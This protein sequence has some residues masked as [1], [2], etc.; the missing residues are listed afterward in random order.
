MV[1]KKYKNLE[2]F[3]KDGMK[4]CWDMPGLAVAVFDSNEILYNYVGGYSNLKTKE[5]LNI[6]DKFCTGSTG[7]SMLCAAI[8]SLIQK[9]KI[10]NIWNMTLSDVWS[11]TIHKDYKNVKV[12]LIA[13]H[14]SGI[15]GISTNEELDLL[16]CPKKCQKME[17][18]MENLD[19]V[20]QRKMLANIILNDPP[21]YVPGK[22]FRYSNWGFGILGA[23]IE[24][25]T[26]MK[27]WEVIDQEIMKPLEIEASYK[28]KYGNGYVNGHLAQDE[29]WWDKNNEYKIIPLNKN[30]HIDTPY[31]D[32]S[33]VLFLSILDCAKYCQ[34]Y[35]KI[36]N[37]EKSILNLKTIKYLTKPMINNY[38]YAWWLGKH[39]YK[40]SI[41]HSG[42][43]Q[44]QTCKFLIIPE[45]NIGIVICSNTS[46]SYLRSIVNEFLKTI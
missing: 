44:C 6:T 19:E 45:K 1:N 21:T 28:Y 22:E 23:I 17:N 20:Q 7:K 33:G 14:S 39:N 3:I 25:L 9:K 41:S 2:K 4:N 46:N 24:K 42:G 12:K 10:P 26:K 40:G 16:N 31:A 32:P 11:K 43:W 15:P 29:L 8:S 5:R 18:K 35:L 13:C 34:S 38:A 37:K 36:L 27:Y 30:Q